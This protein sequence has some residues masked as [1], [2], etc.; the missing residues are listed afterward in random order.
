MQT[1]NALCEIK[2]WSVETEF[3]SVQSPDL[4]PNRANTTDNMD[5]YKQKLSF[6][7]AKIYF[8]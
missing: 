2:F 8:T 3:F 5:Q 4:V 1:I 6:L 7:Y